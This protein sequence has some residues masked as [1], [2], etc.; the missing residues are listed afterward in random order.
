MGVNCDKSVLSG[1]RCAFAASGVVM[2]GLIFGAASLLLSVSA[3]STS[4]D[5]LSKSISSPFEWSSKSSGA[6]TDL[7]ENYR[8]DVR[9]YAEICSRSNCSAPDMSDGVSAIAKKYGISD[10]EAD[11]ATYDAMGRGLARAKVAQA[12]VDLYKNAVPHSSPAD[13]VALQ[14]GYDLGR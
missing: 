1:K 5:S 3:C 12:R 11:R 14:Q 7:V 13:T 9:K 2:A 8:N 6:A 10:W 4:S